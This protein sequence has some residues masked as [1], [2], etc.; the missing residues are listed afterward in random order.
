VTKPIRQI[1]VRALSARAKT[2]LLTAGNINV[3]CVVGRGGFKALKR[4]GDGATPKGVWPLRQLILRPDKMRFV[5]AA[6]PRR[7]LKRDDGWCETPDD[8]R[9]NQPVKVP[10]KA[11]SDHMWRSDDL[12]DAV[13]VLGHNDRPRLRN[14]G[15]AVFFH[16]ARPDF[17]PTAG[18]VAV[19][20]KDMRK[21]LKLCGPKTRMRI[22]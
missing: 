20:R 10:Y 15:S 9:Y 1:H 13:V 2:G 3:R 21:I 12:Y 16:I 7:F 5:L 19:T 4:E 8:P 11:G 22:W 18:C 17:G 14:F 6:L